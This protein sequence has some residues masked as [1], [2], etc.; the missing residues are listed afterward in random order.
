MKL[1]KHQNIVLILADNLAVTVVVPYEARQRR[2]STI[3]HGKGCC[4]KILM[5][6]A[7]AC[8]HVLP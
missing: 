5:L 7:I 8:R 4:F 3:W 1:E 2:G 6:K